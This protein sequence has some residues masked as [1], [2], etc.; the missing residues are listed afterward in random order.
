MK[1]KHTFTIILSCFLICILSLIWYFQFRKGSKIQYIGQLPKVHSAFIF[2]NSVYINSDLV[3]KWSDDNLSVESDGSDLTY[4]VYENKLVLCTWRNHKILNRNEIATDVVI[5]DREGVM[6][7]EFGLNQTVAITYCTENGLILKDSY[8]NSP[9]RVYRLQFNNKFE[10]TLGVRSVSRAV[11]QVVAK[12]IAD[13]VRIPIPVDTLEIFEIADEGYVIQE[14][15]GE[16]WLYPAN[17]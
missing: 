5:R 15:T 11:Y 2:E 10:D 12:E 3:Y 14:V 4:G 17:L 13:L 16:V 9:E 6:Y 7:K 8:E 1:N